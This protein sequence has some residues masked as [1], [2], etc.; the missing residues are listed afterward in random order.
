MDFAKLAVEMSDDNSA[1][2]QTAT[3]GRI[4]PGNGGDLGYFNVFN[5]I[6]DFETAAYNLKIGEISTPVHQ[7]DII[8]LN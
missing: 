8:L 4:I 6:Y 7:V 1:R 5:M 2:E 3:D